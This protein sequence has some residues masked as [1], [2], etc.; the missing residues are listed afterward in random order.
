MAS[1]G[2]QGGMQNL[3]F[4][5]IF[6]ISSYPGELAS[7]SELYYE[8]TQL[9]IIMQ[10]RKLQVAMSLVTVQL[11]PNTRCYHA[12]MCLIQLSRSQSYWQFKLI[13]IPETYSF[14][15]VAETKGIRG[16]RLLHALIL[17]CY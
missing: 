17:L 16:Y 10:G 12:L 8:P 7:A 15:V 13:R 3:E 5:P 6:N 14:F 9:I 2:Y 4:S 11:P 1:K